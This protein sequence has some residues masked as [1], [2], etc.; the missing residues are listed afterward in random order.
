MGVL[1]SAHAPGFITR[2]EAQRNGVDILLQAGNGTGYASGGHCLADLHIEQPPGV[3]V[4]G[5]A[6]SVPEQVAVF[7]YRI[8][9]AKREQCIT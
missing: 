8:G 7:R 1:G 6:D 3:Q 9:E 2:L 5:S 4:I